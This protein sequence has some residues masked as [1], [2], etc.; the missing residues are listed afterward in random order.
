MTMVSARRRIWCDASGKV[1]MVAAVLP[2][3]ARK[4]R[5]RTCALVA[6]L[7]VALSGTAAARVLVTPARPGDN[8]VP[9]VDKLKLGRGAWS[10][11]GDARSVTHRRH[12]FTGFISPKGDV[13]VVETD[14]ETRRTRKRM[15]YRD[16]GVDDHNNP[17]LVFWHG[18]L[19]AFFS[20]HSGRVL[21]KGA[22]MRYRVSRRPHTIRGGFG[23]VRRVP[24]NTPGGLGYTY[25][26]PV[27]AGGRLFL[28]WRG[29]DWNPTFSVTTNGRSWLPARTL[30][31][32]PGTLLH[33]ERPYA[34]YAE[35]PGATFDVAFSDAHVQE[36]HNSL[37]YLRYRRGAFFRADGRRIGTLADVPF[38]RSQVEAVYRWRRGAGRA[39]P[40]DVAAGPDGLP[41]IVYTRRRGGPDGTD[42]FRYARYNGRSWVDREMISAGEGAP[43][44]TSGGITLDHEDPGNVVLSRRVGTYN[45]VELW[46]TFDH[47]HR[48][49]RA[50]LTRY[51]HGFSMRP[52]FPR[53]F[54]QTGKAVVVYF[55]GTAESYTKFATRVIMLVYKL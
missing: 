25:P 30:I 12:V 48:W 5:Q 41:V 34:K 51:Q 47:G 15:I 6:S 49:T 54:H 52:V 42:H 26:N 22:Q 45:Q 14:L 32:G 7:L 16:L 50:T 17:S 20:E 10:Y 18:R 13:W 40:H 37:Y 44:F 39:W 36:W 31:R 23:P 33:P 11:F 55:R 9:S 19:M 38:D 8:F 4:R 28:F 21:G 1:R 27:R 35:G 46:N 43:T 2:V 29:G 53:N 24:T 3:T